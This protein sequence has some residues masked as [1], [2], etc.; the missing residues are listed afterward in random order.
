M[1]EICRA[2][3]LCVCVC[4]CVCMCVWPRSGRCLRLAR[5]SRHQNCLSLKPLLGFCPSQPPEPLIEGVKL[6][7]CIESEWTWRANKAQEPWGPRP[8][9]RHSAFAS[10]RWPRRGGACVGLPEE[11]EGRR[12]V[13][14]VVVGGSL[15][16]R[17]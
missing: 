17:L 4:V 16:I 13:V 2:C 3:S 12:V 9:T 15:C 8:R 10:L 11:G 6:Q 14:V 5:L 1:R 7:K